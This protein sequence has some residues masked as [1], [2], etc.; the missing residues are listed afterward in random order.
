VERYDGA[1]GHQRRRYVSVR[2]E[3]ARAAASH[4][5]A[6]RRPRKSGTGDLYPRAVA[7]PLHATYLPFTAEQVRQHFAPVSVPGQP[8]RHLRYYTRSV[9]RAKRYAELVRT[10]NKPTPAEVR[11]G[12][13]MEKDERF[14]VV[15]ALMRMY[16]ADPGPSRVKLFAQLLERAGLPPMAGFATWEAALAGPL[17]LFFEVNLP[18]P[19]AYS[20]W[21]RDRAPLR[22][23]IRKR[24]SEE[25]AV[26]MAHAR[27]QEERR[28]PASRAPSAPD[29]RRTGRNRRATGVGKLGGLQPRS[30]WLM[31]VADGGGRPAPQL[32]R[33]RSTATST[34]R[35]STVA[36]TPPTGPA[37]KVRPVTG[38]WK[39]VQPL[40]GSRR[41]FS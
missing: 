4:G 2:A 26:R 6:G 37:I 17:F 22:S 16:H 18:S 3:D 21:L 32:I 31:F 1:L 28:L 20:K 29:R 35:I 25:P 14:W 38:V 23:G 10:G 41:T 19:G 30:P 9:E 8:D 7:G 13:Q 40:P 39:A 36:P 5:N 33:S 27:V 11:L 12:R 15:A 34:R 24:R